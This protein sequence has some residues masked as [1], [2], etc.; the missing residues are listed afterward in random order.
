MKIRLMKKVMHTPCRKVKSAMRRL[1]P[2]DFCV[3]KVFG[4]KENSFRLFVAKIVEK[5][6]RG[7][8]V[9]FYT[10]DTIRH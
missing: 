2:G 3:S 9:C 7:Y 6:I 8:E 5:S 10:K 4:K 1:S